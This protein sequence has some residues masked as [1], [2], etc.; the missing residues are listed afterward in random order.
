MTP[1]V[2]LR[3]SAN[4]DKGLGILANREIFILVNVPLEYN[5]FY[6]NAHTLTNIYTKNHTHNIDKHM[7]IRA[8]QF[9]V[10]SR[11]GCVVDKIDLGLFQKIHY[12]K[13]LVA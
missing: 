6:T 8:C 10:L 13:F 1:F 4:L 5:L 11:V 9:S 2:K 12:P 7:Y 3:I